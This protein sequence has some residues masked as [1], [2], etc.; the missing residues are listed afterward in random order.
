MWDAKWNLFLNVKKIEFFICFLK[1]LKNESIVSLIKM[2][3][4]ATTRDL[5]NF[6]LI[7]KNDLNLKFL[8]FD[9]FLIFLDE[10]GR[11]S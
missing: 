7:N 9:G 6:I 5:K 3:N 2:I 10:S 11:N 4:P 1:A 8:Y